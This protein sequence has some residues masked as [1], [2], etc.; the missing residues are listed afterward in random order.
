MMELEN[1][2]HKDRADRAEHEIA[3]LRQQLD[4]MRDELN[5]KQVGTN[6]HTRTHAQLDQMRDELNGKQVGTRT[7][8]RTNTGSGNSWT[9]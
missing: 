9:K 1:K 5:G 2:D 8:T 4:Q 7:N 3:R 6:A